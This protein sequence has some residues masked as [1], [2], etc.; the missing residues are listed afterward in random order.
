MLFVT[1][2]LSRARRSGYAF[3]QKSD[4]WGRLFSY[5]EWTAKVFPNLTDFN[6]LKSSA[7]ELYDCV[8]VT[9]S[10]EIQIVNRFKVDS[11]T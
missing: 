1:K 6:E 3:L 11:I 9:A 5:V 7:H 10:S 2:V 4:D 8:K